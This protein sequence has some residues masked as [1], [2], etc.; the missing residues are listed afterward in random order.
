MATQEA[1]RIF[2]ALQASAA[3]WAIPASVGSDLAR[4]PALSAATE[5]WPR[6]EERQKLNIILGLAHVGAGKVQDQ[7]AARQ[8]AQL[9][10]QDTDWVRVVGGLLGTAGVTGRLQPWDSL[11]E[12]TRSDLQRAIGQ[13][14]EAAEKRGA[15]GLLTTEEM[16]VLE[17]PGGTPQLRGVYGA[18]PQDDGDIAALSDLFDDVAPAAALHVAS[19]HVA[20]HKGRMARLLAAGNS[21][22]HAGAAALPPAAR[23]PSAPMAARRAGSSIPGGAKV[24][25]LVQ[26]R[27]QAPAALPQVGSSAAAMGPSVQKKIVMMDFTESAD[28]FQ[29]RERTLQEQKEKQAEER[30]AKKL[31]AQE[32][33]RERKRQREEAKEAR[34][35]AAEA[36]KQRRRSVPD[37]NTGASSSEDDAPLSKQLASEEPPS[38]AAEQELGQEQED[39]SKEY[40][41]YAGADQQTRAVYQA[42]NALSDIDRLRMFCFFN[43]R[44]MPPGCGSRLEVV[45]NEKRI[46][47]PARP[48][49]QCTEQMI[50]QADLTR[51]EW[52]KVRRMNRD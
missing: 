12:A 2:N 31:R 40:L 52:K 35:M 49:L 50:F 17:H 41:T 43:S 24:G 19:N 9:S 4:G 1:V 42:T 16:S 32:E 11:D 48:G 44:P 18:G 10:S 21:S 20:D 47:D 37:E 3:P 38:D 27:R 7:A 30:E 15:P 28:M 8:I 23:R 34:R 14:A 13:V 25:M 33:A 26:R 39:E 29:A 6:L 51:G 5:M 46:P 36:K 45:L 22:L